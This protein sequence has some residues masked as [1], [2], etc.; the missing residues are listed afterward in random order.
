VRISPVDIEL[1]F[2]ALVKKRGRPRARGDLVGLP[3]QL[4]GCSAQQLQGRVAEQADGILDASGPFQRAG[5]N[6]E[7]PAR[8][9]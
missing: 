8:V 9:S 1:P 2:D 6:G 3:I 4:S 5:I 7:R